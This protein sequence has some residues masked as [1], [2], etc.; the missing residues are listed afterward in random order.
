MILPLLNPEV[1]N[2]EKSYLM[3]PYAIGVTILQLKNADRFALNDRIMVGEMGQ[4]K[5][6]VIT[7]TAALPLMN[8]LDALIEFARAITSH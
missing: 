5:T 2:L 6:E 3:N 8:N 4:E 7:V 1:E